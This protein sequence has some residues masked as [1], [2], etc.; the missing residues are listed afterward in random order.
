MQQQ[1]CPNAKAIIKE[2]AKYT[3]AFAPGKHF[4]PG[5]IFS[6]AV[7]N[8]SGA[9]LRKGLP[10]TKVISYQAFLSMMKRIITST[11]TCINV[12]KFFQFY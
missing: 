4:Q 10:R 8:P 6:S 11:S 5:L 12:T 2:E 7:A 3:R 9:L 1:L